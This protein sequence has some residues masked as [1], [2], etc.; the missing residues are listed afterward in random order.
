MLTMR[1]AALRP[2]QCKGSSIAPSRQEQ[3]CRSLQ[4]ITLASYEPSV[5]DKALNSSPSQCGSSSARSSS[6]GS[7]QLSRRSGLNAAAAS[8]AA[9]LLGALGLT[10]SARADDAQDS[11]RLDKIIEEYSVNEAKFATDSKALASFRERFGFTRLPDGRVVLK[12][13]KG[14]SYSVRLDMEEPGTMLLRETKGGDIFALSVDGLV[15]VRNVSIIIESV[16]L[17]VLERVPE[18]ALLTGPPL[19][20]QSYT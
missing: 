15:Q 16:A 7:Q 9:F 5:A 18:V 20:L 17:T 11:A 19:A 8:S 13:S 1:S 14:L 6:N 2:C 4:R 12:S 3:R 10:P